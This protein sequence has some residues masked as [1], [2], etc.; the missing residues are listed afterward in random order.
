MEVVEDQHRRPVAQGSGEHDAGLTLI[1]AGIDRGYC[2]YPFME[3]D[4]LLS[5]L[6]ADPE[7]AD[8]WAEA[9][10]AG[11]TCHERFLR[12]IGAD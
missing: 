5:G 1:R 10:A 9:V 11:K 4:P 2:S 7:L 8:A 12:E 3:T 6:R